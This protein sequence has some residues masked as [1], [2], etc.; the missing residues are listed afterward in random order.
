MNTFYGIPFSDIM[1]YIKYKRVNTPK[2]RK[3]SLRAIRRRRKAYKFSKFIKNLRIQAMQ[4]IYNITIDPARRWHVIDVST[5]D[6]P[7]AQAIVDKYK[8]NKY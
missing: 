7:I 1:A 5:A 6:I 4:S 2:K 8:A 3:P